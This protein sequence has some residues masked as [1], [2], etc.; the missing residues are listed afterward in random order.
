MV[1][2]SAQTWRG[3]P[4]LAAEP[5]DGAPYGSGWNLRDDRQA[6]TTGARFRCRHALEKAGRENFAE[7]EVIE[8]DVADVAV[9]IELRARARCERG[10]PVGVVDVADRIADEVASPHRAIAVDGDRAVAGTARLAEARVALVVE[11]EQRIDR[12]PDR[13]LVGRVR[14]RLDGVDPDVRRGGQRGAERARS[15][16]VLALPDDADRVADAVLVERAALSEELRLGRPLG[17]IRA[18]QCEPIGVRVRDPVERRREIGLHRAARDLRQ[19]R[20]LGQ[21]FAIPAPDDRLAPRRDEH[22][23]SIGRGPCG[24]PCDEPVPRCL[25]ARERFAIVLALRERAVLAA[26]VAARERTAVEDVEVQDSSYSAMRVR[27]SGEYS[28]G[29]IASARARPAFVSTST[30]PRCSA[31]PRGAR[32]ASSG[33]CASAPAPNFVRYAARS[34]PSS[35]SSDRISQRRRCSPSSRTKP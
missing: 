19:V 4:Q 9:A 31:K 24:Y 3:G 13:D 15:G 1:R 18:P 17:V 30:S 21:A 20:E 6:H 28:H 8:V 2:G 10:L 16:F 5:A 27:T 23:D 14:Q 11:L 35:E 34:R 29:P 22:A 12:A 32:S 7:L 26:V 25:V 33:K